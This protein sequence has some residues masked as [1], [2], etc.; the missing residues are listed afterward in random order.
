MALGTTVIVNPAFTTKVFT[1]LG[2]MQPLCTLAMDAV[3]QEIQQYAR[4]GKDWNDTGTVVSYNGKDTYSVT[5]AAVES[6]AA[7][8]VGVPRDPFHSFSMTDPIS[9]HVHSSDPSV[10][11]VPE[12]VPG[13]VRGIVTM[14]ED[15]TGY[16]QRWEER[17]PSSNSPNLFGG[18][19]LTQ[20]VLEYHADFV[21]AALTAE[22]LAGLARL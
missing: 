8:A 19:T 20:E 5:G 21:I 10:S 17:G 15:H 13:L 6:I 12:E 7:Y 1:L 14:A 18:T 2:E 22:V 4:D 16:L 11:P 3:M 9:G